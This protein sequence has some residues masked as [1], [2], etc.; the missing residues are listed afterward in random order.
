MLESPFYSTDLD[1]DYPDS[2]KILV[3]NLG[4][5]VRTGGLQYFDQSVIGLPYSLYVDVKKNW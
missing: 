3:D 4:D 5:L 1:Q 2:Y